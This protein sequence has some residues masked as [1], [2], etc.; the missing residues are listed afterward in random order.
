MWTVEGGQAISTA[1]GVKNAIRRNYTLIDIKI[2]IESYN[3]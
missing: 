2:N 3:M 1:R